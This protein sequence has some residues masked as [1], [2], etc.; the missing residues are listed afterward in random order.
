MALEKTDGVVTIVN[1]LSVN[2][3]LDSVAELMT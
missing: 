2:L 1:N 3:F